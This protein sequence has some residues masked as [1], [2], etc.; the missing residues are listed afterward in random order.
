[1]NDLMLFFKLGLN[2]VLDLNAYDHILFLFVLVVPY[3][4][5]QWKELLGLITAFTVGHTLTLTLAIYGIIHLKSAFIEFLIPFT[6]FVTAL[7]NLLSGVKNK[8]GFRFKLFLTFG[9][10]WIHGLGFSYYLQMLLSD[11]S[12]KI[13]PLIQFA[14][15]IEA[16]Q[17][18]IA[19]L[20]LVLFLVANKSLRISKRD[21]I[22]VF[23][24]IVM[25]I[26]IP[27]MQERWEPFVKNLLS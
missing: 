10:G 6:I 17:L 12:S 4:T 16:A 22:L 19:F 1:M 25:G 11:A 27:M 5:K 14:L 24:A 9:F 8:T 15:G 2:H 21:W 23:S 7:V 26:V 3:A 20:M 13:L 18:V